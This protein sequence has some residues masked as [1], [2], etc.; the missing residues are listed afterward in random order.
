[1]AG[2]STILTSAIEGFYWN[3]QK[4]RGIGKWISNCPLEPTFSRTSAAAVEEDDE[5][6]GIFQSS[7]ACFKQNLLECS[8]GLEIFSILI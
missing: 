4:A 1:M 8:K 2:F 3:V 5:R 6:R 7:K